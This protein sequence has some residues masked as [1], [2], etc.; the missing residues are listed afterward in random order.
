MFMFIIYEF[1]HNILN[2]KNNK[3][4]FASKTYNYYSVSIF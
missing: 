3:I 4:I 1:F 2:I